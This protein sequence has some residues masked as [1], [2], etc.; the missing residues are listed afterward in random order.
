[1]DGT[2]YFFLKLI[3]SNYSWDNEFT[4]FEKL[5][6]QVLKCIGVVNRHAKNHELHIG[7]GHAWICHLCQLIL[8]KTLHKMESGADSA[9][10]C[11]PGSLTINGDAS[12]TPSALKPV[13]S[14]S[15]RIAVSSG[16]SP[17]SISPGTH[18]FNFRI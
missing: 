3:Q 7:R 12:M 10:D 5:L 6:G 8:Y 14:L 16:V 4:L 13:S 1:M 18:D 15:S 11:G 17:S 9:N 2:L